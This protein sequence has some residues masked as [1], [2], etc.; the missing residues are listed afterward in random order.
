MVVV[1][2]VEGRWWWWVVMYEG[3]VMGGVGVEDVAKGIARSSQIIHSIPP[4]PPDEMDEL[5]IILKVSP[6]PSP[7]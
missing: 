3:V 5:Y 6:S 1:V 7:F 4:P 2:V